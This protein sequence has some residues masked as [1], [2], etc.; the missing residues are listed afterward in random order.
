MRTLLLA[1]A[2]VSAIAT[3]T[4]ANNPSLESCVK[5]AEAD[6]VFKV[7][8]EEAGERAYNE[9]SAIGSRINAEEN[10]ARAVYVD[11][12][13]HASAI[14]YKAIPP[15]EEKYDDARYALKAEK[16]KAIGLLPRGEQLYGDKRA[17]IDKR[18]DA[19]LRKLDKAEGKE[20]R[21]VKD[22]FYDAQEKALKERDTKLQA[23]REE[24]N[25]ASKEIDDAYKAAIA[26]PEEAR[27]KIYEEAY[28]GPHSDDPEIMKKLR[29][30]HRERCK[31]LYDM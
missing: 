27:R 13:D 1:T 25:R 26:K 6:N 16:R 12:F 22:V 3:P 5:Y 24:Y 14:R 4:L 17:R 7:A 19:E 10:K 29:L 11:V 21:A 8:T 2:L 20:I 9:R 31:A 15:I 23:L 18:F 28:E 30:R